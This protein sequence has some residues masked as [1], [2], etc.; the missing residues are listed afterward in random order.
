MHDLLKTVLMV[1]LIVFILQMG[2]LVESYR[3]LL[4]QPPM[5][6]IEVQ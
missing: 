6:C 3:K 4:N 2:M 5:S 1:C